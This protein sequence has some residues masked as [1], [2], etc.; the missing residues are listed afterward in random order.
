[1]TEIIKKKN[2]NPAHLKEE[3]N[4]QAQRVGHTSNTTIINNNT[5][6][7]NNIESKC[8]GNCIVV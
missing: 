7:N 1:M 8:T 3:K 6:N 4:K 2:K 5:Y